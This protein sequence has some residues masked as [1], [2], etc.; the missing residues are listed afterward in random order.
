[1][2]DQLKPGFEQDGYR[3]AGGDPANPRSWHP[4]GMSI[5]SI[6]N[7]F[8][9]LGG[10]PGEQTNWEKVPERTWGEATKDLG[11][12]L[13][14]SVVSTAK[15]AP[16]AVGAV[17]SVLSKAFGLGEPASGGALKAVEDLGLNA[18]TKAINEQKSKQLRAK[19]EASANQAQDFGAQYADSLKI[20]G[21]EVG[22]IA[23]ET[24][25]SI[26]NYLTDPQLLI[27]GAAENIGPQMVASTAGRVAQKGALIAAKELAP[28]MAAET[29]DKTARRVGL[30]TALTVGA[31][32]QGSDVASDT[33]SRLLDMKDDL[34]SRNEDYNQLTEQV[35]AQ[36]AKEIVAGQLATEA[37]IKAG[38][39]SLAVN[40]GMAK[41]G[42]ATLEGLFLKGGAKES[43]GGLIKGAAKGFGGESV[44]EALEEGYGA[45]AGN[46]SAQQIDPTINAYQGVGAAAGQGAALG[47][48]MGGVA[49]GFEGAA[50]SRQRAELE[51][52]KALQEMAKAPDAGGAIAGANE[53]AGNLDN[54][55][56]QE[57]TPATDALLGVPASQTQQTQQPQTVDAAI[58]NAQRTA[59]GELLPGQLEVQRQLDQQSG[60]PIEQ[61]TVSELPVVG[62]PTL[63]EPGARL[64]L[65]AM[66]ANMDRRSDLLG[67]A[68]NAGFEAERQNALAQEQTVAEGMPAGRQGNN[69]ADLTP[70]NQMQARQRLAVLRDENPGTIFAA[71][72][73]PRAQGKFA[74]RTLEAP[75]AQPNVA[76]PAPVTATEQQR[77]EGAAM[78]GD[79]QNR[80]AEDSPRQR[81]ISRAMANIE[82][83]GGVASPMEA[84]ILREANLGRPFNSIDPN[85]GRQASGDE[86]LT[87]ATGIAVGSE[88]GQ[89]F[90]ARES[91]RSQPPSAPF[92]YS[93]DLQGQQRDQQE[94]PLIDRAQAFVNVMSREN[95]PTARAFT[96]AFNAGRIS[97]DDVSSMLAEREADPTGGRV[98]TA[99]AGA[100]QQTGVQV[101]SELTARQTSPELEAAMNLYGNRPYTEADLRGASPRM[102]DAASLGERTTSRAE[103]D[104]AGTRLAAAAEQGRLSQPSPNTIILSDAKFSTQREPVVGSTDTVSDGDTQHE[105]TVVEGGKV[106]GMN[107]LLRQLA[108]TF[109]KRVVFFTSDTLKADGFVRNG[110]NRTIYLNADS[111]MNPLAVFGHELMHLIKRDNPVAYR[112]VAAVIASRMDA[113][114]RAKFRADYGSGANLEELSSDLLGNAFSDENFLTEVFTEIGQLAPEG[115]ARGIVMRF[116]AAVNKAVKAAI[117]VVKNGAYAAEGF[118]ADGIVKNLEEIR[119]ALKSALKTYAGQQIEVARQLEAEQMRAEAG[120][121]LED[122]GRLTQGTASSDNVSNANKGTQNVIQR[123]EPRGAAGRLESAE[124]N[125]SRA[126]EDGRDQGSAVPSYGE[127]REGAIQVR[128]VHYS[129]AART[130]LDGRFW[131]TGLRGAEAARLAQATDDRLRQRVYFYV[132]TGEGIRPEGGVGKVEHEVTLNNLYDPSTG[133]IPKAAYTDANGFESAVI[134]AGFDGYVVP[135]GR[136]K[137]AVLL[138]PKHTA[139]PVKA[140]GTDVQFARQRDYSVVE[141]AS[142]LENA[143]AAAREGSFN[144][145]RE[146]KT[147]LQDRVNAAAR[148]ARVDLKSQNAE[149]EQYLVRQTVADALYAMQSNANAVGWYD[150][151]VS[152]ALNILATMH[153]E[154]KTDPNAQFAFSWALA[155]TSNG[156]KVDKNFELAER[157][158]EHYVRT[159]KMPTNL[160]AGK[161]QKKINDS[162]GLLNQMVEQFTID[163]VRKL[164]LT[165]LTVSQ[166]ERVTGETV[167]GEFKDTLVR[168]A[169]ILGPKIGNG[170]YSNL[171]GLF[172]QLTM[173]RWLMRTWGRWTGTLI[174]DRPDMV[175]LKRAELRGLIEQMKKNA[176]AAVEF[177]KTLG[178]KLTVGNLDAVARA[179][180]KASQKPENR[181]AFNKTEVGE[182]LRKTGNA[183]AKYLD[184]Q[185]EAPEGPEERG[186]IRKVFAQALEELRQ[187]YPALTMADLQ[188]LLWYPEKRLYDVAKSNE[189]EQEGYEDDEAP[190]YANA[191][192]KLARANGISQAQ[193]DE[194]SKEAETDYE[195]RNSAG[196]ARRSDGGETETGDAAGARGFTRAEQREFVTTNIVHGIRSNRERDGESSGP[197][198][199]K[200]GGNGKGFRVLGQPSAAVFS[201]AAKFKNAL[202]AIPAAAPKFF[203]LGADSA[204]LFHDSI[205]AAKDATP[206]GAAVY[207]YPEE[208]YRG[209]RLFLTEDGKAGFALKGDDIVSVFSGAPHAGSV[210]AMMQLAVQEGGRRLDAFDTV[211]PELYSVHGFKAVARLGWNNEFAPADWNKATFTEFNGGEPDVV[212][213]V[214][215]PEYFGKYTKADGQRVESYDGAVA[216][217]QQAVGGDITKS[218]QRQTDTPEFKRWSRDLP[219]VEADFADSYDGGPAVFQ[220]YHGTTH[221]DITE[222]KAIGD[223]EGALGAGPYMST[224]VGDVNENYAGVGPDLTSRIGREE[225]SVRDGFYDDPWFATQVLQDYFDAEGVDIEVTD[226]NF[227]ELKDEHGDKAISHTAMKRLKGGSDGLVMPVYVRMEKPFNMASNPTMFELT[228]PQNKEGEPDYE[229][230]PAG[231]AIDLINA[232][233][234]VAGQ[235]N[236]DA[237]SL[238]G[239]VYEN[240]V[241]GVSAREVFDQASKD[242]SD[243]YDDNGELISSGQFIQDVARE[244]GFD[245]LIQDADLYFGTQ[246]RGLGGIR[247]GAMKGVNPGTLHL[248]PFDGKQV[249]SATGNNGEFG[250][251]RDITKSAQRRTDSPQ[252]K[253]WFG[254]SKVVDGQ[255]K[256]LVVYHGTSDEIK[257]G[258]D[259][260]N[261][262]R[263]DTG[264]LGTGVYLT[265]SDFIAEEYAYKKAGPGYE[266]AN[267]LPLY[268]R[269]ENPYYATNEDKKRLKNGGREAADQFTQELKNQGY[270]GVI[271]QLLPDAREI[272][273]FNPA[274]VKSVTGNSGAFDPS[275]PDITQSKKRI[276][277]DSKRQYTPEQKAMFQNVGRTVEVPTLKERLKELRKDMG[278]KLAQGIFD[279]FAPLKELSGK[280]YALARLSKGA[281]GAFEAML[282]HGKL[283]IKDNVYD[284]DQSG[285]FIER[286]GVPLHGELE[287]FLW[288][289]AANRAERLA[290]E[291]RE[292]LFT[293]ADIAG[294]KSLD[295]GT[296]DYDYMLQHGPNAGKTTRD[297]TLIFRDALKTLDEFNK[298][299]MDMAEQSGLIDKDSRQYWENEF[300]VPFYRVSDEDGSFIGAKLKGGQVR[301][302][303]FK[304]LRGGKEKINSDI[305]SNVLQNW[306]H[307]IDAAA[308]NRA[309]KASLEAAE[310]MG[311]AIEADE[312]TAKQIA[313]SINK[314]SSAVWFMDGGQ[315]RFFVV[316][317]PMIMSAITSLE[318]AGMRNPVMDVMSSFKKWLTIGVTASPA[319]KV[320]N[321]IRDSIQAIGTSDLSYNPITNIREG[322]KASDR[323][324]QT[325]VSALA[326]G[327]LIRFGTMLEGKQSDRVRQLVRSGVKDS[328][329]LDSDSKVQAM[330]DQYLEPAITAYNELGNRGEEI[331]RAALFKQLKDQGMNQAEAALLARD[332]MDFSMQGSWAAVRF[333]TQV[334]P[335]MNARLQGLYKLGRAA[336]EDPRRFS[337]VL[338]ATAMFSVALML[339]YGDDDDWKKREDWD[340]DNFWWFK[341]GGTAFRIPKPFEIGAIATLAE[342]GVEYF[343]EPEMTGKRFMDRFKHILLDQLSM[344][345]VPQAFK[346]IVDIYANKDSFSGRP[347]ETMGM[348]K[349][350]SQY[351][352]TSNTSMTARALSTGTGGLLSPVQY[353]QIIR[354]YFG[355]LGT[356]VVAG[357]DMAVRPMTNEPTRPQAD[358]WKM[359]TSGFVQE[360]PTNQ[361]RYVTQMYEEAKVVEEAYGTWR[362]LLKEGRYDEAK[363]FYADNASKMNRYKQ[364]ENVKSSEA[365]LNEYIRMIENSRMSPAEKKAKIAEMQGVKDRVARTLVAR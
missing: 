156:L 331:N 272:V 58:L 118:D 110:D 19:E 198:S 105:M 324:S 142:K 185:K 100:P 16:L 269:V 277:G 259:L 26:K 89:G 283:S 74:I 28:K 48:F 326:S 121:K 107:G 173:D 240:A 137:A 64:S 175:R 319:F 190:D 257:G 83:R 171:N 82:S 183:L 46:I 315:K 194:A 270:D 317:D 336:K 166:I 67:Q 117:A 359:A 342:R 199:R 220:A 136:G 307:L 75:T 354:G 126:A 139:V 217:Q 148:A 131:G 158:Y 303:A 159:G 251:T 132:D 101:A 8:K 284:G 23:A 227:D 224:S 127:A 11:L 80:R 68:A 1:M 73:H 338:G 32:Q 334:V 172:D 49:G 292:H 151:T 197:Y 289:V 201:P 72:A 71:T 47:G 18:A 253:R 3:F 6:D 318:F 31:A 339:A 111:Q 346:P 34:W 169:A 164:M 236:A 306:A 27:A 249:K 7:G 182:E 154:I 188:A 181:E 243:L 35:G 15:L 70:M 145:N 362:G 219:I 170:F 144:K 313:K 204:P 59:E 133:L 206:F 311:V 328:T 78:V 300:Y 265:D 177:Q 13:A 124:T 77:L 214:Y 109:G 316:D 196:P 230:E 322:I 347:I 152:K 66:Q 246:R 25:Y 42:G 57:F 155:V 102:Q 357:A 119:A 266:G 160:Q 299:T 44:T 186:F 333:L 365:K 216:L 37:G 285:G 278:K 231:S 298:N 235:Y 295:N 113:E 193:I 261:P 349:K 280:A 51:R 340:R 241:D 153:P 353:D 129:K 302:T 120:I 279:Q 9:F 87:A 104:S 195:T 351:R 55:I 229:A 200:S 288:W 314:T 94:L 115:E 208:E 138:G 17:D 348:E 329:I 116:A 361:S 327:G 356:F 163:N 184:G 4:A 248:M 143:F 40:G 39:A 165:E 222:F 12:S 203:E 305:L 250:D 52:V 84:E 134:D 211:L 149:T 61:R 86:K 281:T 63:Q 355:W 350:Q 363:E 62:S 85:L 221:T 330:Y 267:V 79:Q 290:K 258:F 310:K 275:N 223:K 254:D 147:F 33:Y 226:D 56:R 225:D 301:Q 308:K 325:Y 239:W 209:M 140:R 297:R 114:T 108:R 213:M 168:G 293:A 296:T 98:A 122:N 81:M 309:A 43:T 162:L 65:P 210:N 135:F 93:P 167:T 21:V 286:L 256:P 264:W 22:R 202:G 263:M 304:Q 180:E 106:A 99:A 323:N 358:Y 234:E 103:Q 260:N 238:T 10:N 36:R 189:D 345:P 276:V 247:A 291:D 228:Y 91:T 97:M 215:D 174:E 262:N 341:L 207:V 242:I 179:I 60:L 312:A 212:F 282:H 321:L 344:N 244:M 252:F 146:L 20:G 255:G 352:Y 364:V 205:Q 130:F 274:A 2:A 41:F 335:F 245:G 360:L 123:S 178:R 92:K 24:A 53:L 320:R 76:A 112:A 95:T 176:P 343:A 294:G 337:T 271:L 45:Y 332:L 232:I 157:A 69:F 191:A 150:K 128:G 88:A 90:G 141:T 187:Q 237:S 54:I 30:G 125:G 14:N 38:L 161:T 5:G 29:I 192:A 50:H 218:A 96:Q 233:E 287:D 268:A 273:V